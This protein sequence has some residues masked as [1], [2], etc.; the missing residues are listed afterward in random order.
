MW[1][2]RSIRQRGGLLVRATVQNPVGLLKP[3]MF[4]SVKILIAKLRSGLA[5][6]LLD[7]KAVVGSF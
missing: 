7:R 4:A 1:R 5:P 6:R 3:E 2:R